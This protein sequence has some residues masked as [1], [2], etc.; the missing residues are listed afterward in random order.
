MALADKY[1]KLAVAEEAV[2]KEHEEMKKDYRA[3][4]ASLPKQTR[5]KALA[6]MDQHCDALISAAKKKA[7]EYNAIAK[8]HEIRASEFK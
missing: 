5:E 4:Q 8:W 7:E 1:K 2:V 6:E 3:N